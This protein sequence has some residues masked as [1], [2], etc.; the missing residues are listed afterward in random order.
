MNYEATVP[1]LAQRRPR[2]HPSCPGTYALILSSATD[3]VIPVGRLGDLQ[4]KPGFYVYVGSALGPGGVSAR[5]AYHMRP[6]RRPH[7]HLDYLKAHTNILEVW[8]T[9]GRR[10]REHVWARYFAGIRGATVPMVGFGS[11]DCDCESH[12][13]FF[14]R[15]PGA[16]ELRSAGWHHSGKV[17]EN[18]RTTFSPI[19]SRISC[20]DIRAFRNASVTKGTPVASNGVVVAPSKSE[21]NATC[22]TPT[23]LAVY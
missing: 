11:S 5:L 19:M 2:H 17:C 15:R 22:S 10:P 14:R 4:L 1:L 13:F 7:W 8:F 12:L 16:G 20:S 21:P 18:T 6:V 3:I 23:T 9:Y